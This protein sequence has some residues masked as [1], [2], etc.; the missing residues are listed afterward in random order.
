MVVK[1]GSS[2]T[3]RIKEEKEREIVGK[4]SRKQDFV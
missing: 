1:K 4:V 2:T 3:G